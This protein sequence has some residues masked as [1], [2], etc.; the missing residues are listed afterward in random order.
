VE[1][2]VVSAFHSVGAKKLQKGEKVDC[3]VLV[4]GDD[5]AAKEAIIT[6]AGWW[7]RGGSTGALAN[8]VALEALTSVL[9]G[10]NRRYK[11]AGAGIRVT[12]I[13]I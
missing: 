9:I 6:L 11:V 12:G 5:A 2:R 4:F 10:I 1:T 8:A 13:P 3:D 7:R